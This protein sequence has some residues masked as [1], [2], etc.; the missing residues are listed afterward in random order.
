MKTALKYLLFAA[1][2]TVANLLTQWISFK[3]YDGTVALYVAMSFGTLVGLVV[4]Y[5]LDKKWIFYHTPKDKKDD[6]QKF[7]L[8][9]FMGVFTTLIF[10]GTEMGFYYLTTLPY[11]QYVGAFIGLSVGYALKYFLDKRFVFVHR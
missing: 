6:A 2:S 4:K 3:A 9:S 7:L 10:W 11:K 8:Y 1:V 5:Y